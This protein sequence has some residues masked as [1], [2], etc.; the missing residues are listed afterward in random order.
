MHS[1]AHQN[2]ISLSLDLLIKH[3]FALRISEVG[4]KPVSFDVSGRTA[5]N[6]LQPESSVLDK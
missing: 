2:A 5:F 4:R 6:K 1:D 3:E